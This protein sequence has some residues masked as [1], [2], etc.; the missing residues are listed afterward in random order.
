MRLSYCL[1][2]VIDKNLRSVRIVIQKVDADGIVFSGV[3]SDG[4]N[5]W[6]SMQH[7]THSVDVL[8]HAR[9]YKKSVFSKHWQLY[10]T[11]TV[12]TANK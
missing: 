8:C 5:F 7:V 9:L 3:L 11:Y 2:S 10:G 1:V 12:K 4:L 6:L